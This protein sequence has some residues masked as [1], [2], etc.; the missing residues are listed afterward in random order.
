MIFIVWNI[1]AYIAITL[2]I[3]QIGFHLG[4]ETARKDAHRDLYNALAKFDFGHDD[5]L[6]KEINEFKED[7]NANSN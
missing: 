1:I 2:I 3:L 6:R 7:D 5:I 4:Y